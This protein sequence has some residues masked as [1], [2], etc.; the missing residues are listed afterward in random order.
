V[1]RRSSRGGGVLK[2]RSTFR[3]GGVTLAFDWLDDEIREE[4]SSDDDSAMHWVG[5]R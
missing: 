2:P 3:V 5:A 4:L 1:A